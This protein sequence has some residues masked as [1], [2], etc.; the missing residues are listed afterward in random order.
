MT[1]NMSG[2]GQA[3]GMT[4]SAATQLMSLSSALSEQ[5][6]DLQ[7]EVTSFVSTLRAA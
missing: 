2:V 5:S 3:A 1:N 4:G 7:R 6:Q